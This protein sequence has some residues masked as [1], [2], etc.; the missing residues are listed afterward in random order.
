MPHVGEASS[1][2]ISKSPEQAGESIHVLHN[3]M[4][5]VL[6]IE[7][8]IPKFHVDTTRK[9]P[10]QSGLEL[11]LQLSA[12]VRDNCLFTRKSLSWVFP[13]SVFTYTGPDDPA[14]VQLGRIYH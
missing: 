1:N 9:P 2:E 10:S 13:P 11:N 8:Q 12:W 14:A 5:V 6:S 3:H 7:S 4:Y